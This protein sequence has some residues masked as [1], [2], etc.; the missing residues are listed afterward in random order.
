[1]LTNS[2]LDIYPNTILTYPFLFLSNYF[3]IIPYTSVGMV[4]PSML[5][6][7]LRLRVPL[8]SW[9][10][11][12]KADSSLFSVS[13]DSIFIDD[14]KNSILSTVYNYS[15]WTQTYPYPLSRTLSM[16]PS[17]PSK[18]PSP[19]SSGK[20]PSTPRCLSSHPRSDPFSWRTSS[21]H[22]SLRCCLRSSRWRLESLPAS[23]SE[24]ILISVYVELLHV[25]QGL[26]QISLVVLDICLSEL[27]PWVGHRLG[28][29]DSFVRVHLQ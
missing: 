25:A 10:S 22:L 27:E 16:P 9:S 13:E 7:S 18:N 26:S 15:Q 11:M 19:V 24:T 6:N 14:A 1:M 8:P 23:S 12:R 20:L 21:S 2:S 17:Q 5:F 29:G 3:T 4:G 28:C